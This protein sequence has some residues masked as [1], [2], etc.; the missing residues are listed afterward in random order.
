[1]NS[2]ERHKRAA[3][4]NAQ[5]D[6]EFQ[7]LAGVERAESWRP[8][9][10]RVKD[11]V[12]RPELARFLSILEQHNRSPKI[13]PG[14]RCPAPGS[15]ALGPHLFQVLMSVE[16]Q[17][18]VRSKLPKFGQP[19]AEMRAH[20]QD[21]STKCRALADVIRGGPQPHV[22]L[23]AASD[24]N[25]VLRIF[26]PMTELFKASAY[27]ECEVVAFTELLERAG[28]WFGALA[29]HVPRG[30]HNRHAGAGVLRVRASEF[31]VGVFRRKL[32]RPYHTHVATLA[33]VISEIPTDADFVKKVEARGIGPGD[34]DTGTESSEES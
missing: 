18:E 3:S 19:A 32:G 33:T 31:L 15:F 29:G 28:G 27:S 30:K 14:R 4:P 16:A 34:H 2:R 5:L 1:M 11:I 22:A 9:V 6:L 21:V 24:A 25:A 20:L 10:E 26:I 7:S 17:H 12:Q 8:I 23:A 13:I